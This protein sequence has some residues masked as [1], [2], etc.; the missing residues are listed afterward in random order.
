MKDLILRVK[1]Y[2]TF[3]KILRKFHTAVQNNPI[4][5]IDFNKEM[6]SLLYKYTGKDIEFCAYLLKNVKVI[7]EYEEV[8][9]KYDLGGIL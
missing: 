4:V 2:F 5:Y 6:R 9:V 3:K 8:I 1:R 7:R